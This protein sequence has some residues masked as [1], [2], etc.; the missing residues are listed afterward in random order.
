MV[1]ILRSQRR[2][3]QCELF[4]HVRIQE[5]EIERDREILRKIEILIEKDSKIEI[6]RERS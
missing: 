6:L 2:H 1:L 4:I 3:K 5:R